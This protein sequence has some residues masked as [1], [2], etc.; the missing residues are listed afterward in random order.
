MRVAI[1]KLMT[2]VLPLYSY[3]RLRHLSLIASAPASVLAMLAM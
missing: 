2:C 3:F 1:M